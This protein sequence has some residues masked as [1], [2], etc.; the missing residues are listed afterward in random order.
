VTPEAQRGLLH[1]LFEA[2]TYWAL[3]T[4]R[5]A[6]EPAGDGTWWVTL[7]VQARKETVD[8]DGLA[9]EVPLDEEVEVGVYAAGKEEG[10]LGEPLYLERHRLRSGAQSLRVKV[11]G[12]PARAGIDPRH[13]LIDVNPED[14]VQ[15]VPSPSG[16]GT[17]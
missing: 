13:L 17:G 16:R 12:E 5:A 10:E 11:K 15:A 2:N 6:A 1:D 4:K 9:T 3:Q 14:N 8:P 7:D